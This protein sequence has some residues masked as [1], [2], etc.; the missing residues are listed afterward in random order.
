MTRMEHMLIRMDNTTIARTVSE[1]I[2]EMLAEAGIS[3][4]RAAEAA[5]IPQATMHR[6]MNG[7]SPLTIAELDALA[8]VAGTTAADVVSRAEQRAPGRNAS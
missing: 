3:H 1:T 8:Q 7:H 2:A 4:R 6:R 5:G